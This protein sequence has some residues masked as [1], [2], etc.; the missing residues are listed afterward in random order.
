MKFGKRLVRQA[1]SEWV[2]YYL[3]YKELKLQ[4]QRSLSEGDL[5]GKAW[6]Q[7]LKEE[8]QRINKFF[9]DKESLLVRQY[10][11]L[12]QQLE[13]STENISSLSNSFERYCRTLEIM[14]YYVVLNY[15]AIY[16]IIKKRNKT[17][18]SCAP[19]DFTKILV[20]QPFYK[21]IKLA[22]LT[23]KTELFALKIMPKEISVQNFTCPICLDVLCNPVVL[24]CTHRFCWS[25]LSTTST[26]LQACPVCRK[27]QQLDPKNFTIDWILRDF[28]HSQFPNSQLKLQHSEAA[29]GLIK[30]LE[31]RASSLDAIL[32]NNQTAEQQP[33]LQPIVQKAFPDVPSTMSPAPVNKT[34]ECKYAVTGKL[35]VGVFG[36]V[37]LATSKA[38]PSSPPVALKKLVKN[39]PK[40]K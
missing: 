14:R 28:L 5:E 35:G 9:V 2:V 21:S 19:I 40:F 22:R 20:D 37:F 34:N 15:M 29:S 25:C 10:S 30:Q 39:H 6:N 26:T 7:F 18:K 8:L 23:V 36:E 1:H 27:G 38:D 33:K 4:L 17:L 12:E 32:D 3:N 13:A 11:L 16:K 24:S 31:K